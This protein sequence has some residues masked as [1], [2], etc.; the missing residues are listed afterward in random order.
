MDRFCEVIYGFCGGL[1][2]NYGGLD[3]ISR[4]EVIWM[5]FVELLVD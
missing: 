2:G 1:S 4:F 3:G 5:V